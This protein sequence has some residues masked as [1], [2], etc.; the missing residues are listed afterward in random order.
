M[1]P[2]QI[3]TAAKNAC[4]ALASFKRWLGHKSP[5][6]DDDWLKEDIVNSLHLLETDTDHESHEMLDRDGIVGRVEN[7]GHA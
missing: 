7:L 3:I 5:T 6:C 1:T 2:S 4:P